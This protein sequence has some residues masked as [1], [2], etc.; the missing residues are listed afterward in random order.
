[1][2]NLS[3]GSDTPSNI[4]TGVLQDATA[5]GASVVA[6]VGNEWKRSKLHSGQLN[7]Y[8][9]DARDNNNT[10]IPGVI[11]AGALGRFRDKSPLKTV[12]FSQEGAYLDVF[13]PGVGIKLN[14]PLTPLTPGTPPGTDFYDGTSFAAP[15]VS[16]G[17]A[18]AKANKPGASPGDLENLI[19]STTCSARGK[20]LIRTSYG[21]VP[22][23]D[24]CTP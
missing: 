22:L 16:G 10:P 24:I 21:D 8:P 9:A 4:L 3:L 20:T 14:V 18:I 1:V 17:V 15:I 11:G 23:L 6:S 2:L 12:N 7:H 19:K 5:A 13:A